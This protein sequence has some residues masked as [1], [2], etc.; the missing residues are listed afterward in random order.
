MFEKNFNKFYWLFVAI[1][2]VVVCLR[3]FNIPFSHDEAASFFFYIQSD[4]Y[5]PYKAH[6]Y[7]NNHILNSALAN[8]CYHIAGSHRFVLRIPNILA[9]LLLCIGVYRNFRYMKTIQAKV[10]VSVLFLFTLNFLDFF[11][12]CRGYGLSMGLMMLGLSYLIDFFDRAKFKSLVYFSILWQLALAANMILVAVILVLLCYIYVFQYKRRTEA[13]GRE[14]FT[15]N[16]II[17]QAI[18]LG[19]IAF[20]V[21]FSFF[22]KDKGVLDYGVGDNYWMVSFKTLIDFLFGTDEIWFQVLIGAAYAIIFTFLMIDIWRESFYIRDLFKPDLFYSFT[23]LLLVGAFFMQKKLL[24]VNYPEDRTGLFFYLFF[25]M[26][27]GFLIDKRPSIFGTIGTYAVTTMSILYFIF[28][29]NFTDFTSWL[30]HTMP[31]SIYDQL[32]TILEKEKHQITIGGHRVREMNYAFTNYRGGARLNAMDNSEEMQMNCDYYFAQ[33]RERPYYKFFYDEIGEDVVWDRVLLKRKEPIEHVMMWETWEP[34]TFSSEAEFIDFKR[35]PD[36]VYKSKNP[37][38]IE[39][40][41]EFNDVPKPFNAFFVLSLNDG[42]NNTYHYKRSPL[43]WLGKD[44]NG[45][46]KYFKLTTG[47][48]PDTVRSFVVHIWNIDKKPMKVTM[49]HLAIYQL[50]GKGVNFK[51]PAAYYPLIEKITKKPLL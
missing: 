31:K 36:T 24:G 1:S 9:F 37:I 41:L 21:R 26:S 7:T 30:Y 18:N 43:H 28:N 13:G 40:E 15:K 6:V 49:K 32:I 23:F 17:L 44:L 38:E 14:L 42:K 8:L 10:M 33:K 29:L 35:L 11:E 2:F 45:K 20:W 27:L 16:N 12:L 19:L 50:K 34:Q 3:A 51:I 22:Y 46:T 39:A 25:V 47:N 4:D 48:L 5:L